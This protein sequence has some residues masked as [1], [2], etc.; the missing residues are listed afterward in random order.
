MQVCDRWYIV[1]ADR[2]MVKDDELP[3]TWGLMAPSGTALRVAVEAKTPLSP[4][5]IDRPFLAS[6]VTLLCP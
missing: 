4:V 2:N 5:P 6:I 1:A 3:P